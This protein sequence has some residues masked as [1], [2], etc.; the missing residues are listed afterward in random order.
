MSQ[1]DKKRESEINVLLSEVSKDKKIG[2]FKLD[3]DT[4]NEFQSEFKEMFLRGKDNQ[5]VSINV[6]EKFV[7]MLSKDSDLLKMIA[8]YKYGDKLIEKEIDRRKS[9][10]E[11]QLGVKPRI[12]GIAQRQGGFI[13]PI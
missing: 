4:F 6:P 9:E 13:E 11:E 7:N 12:D 8:Y 5:L 2:A 10:L 1:F 3:D